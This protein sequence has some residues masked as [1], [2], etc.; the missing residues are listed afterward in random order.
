MLT[1]WIAGC[2][3]P[4]SPSSSW[5]HSGPS[6][7][8][9][10][11][12]GRPVTWPSLPRPGPPARKMGPLRAGLL[13]ATRSA[14]R[15]H[16]RRTLCPLGRDPRRQ[17]FDLALD[18]SGDHPGSRVDAKKKSLSASERVESARQA[19]RKLTAAIEPA[20]WVW[21]DEFGSTTGLTRRRTPGRRAGSG[22]TPA[23]PGNHGP[24]RTTITS[25][26]LAGLGP[27]LILDEAMTTR[28]VRVLRPARAGPDAPAGP[29]RRRWTTS[30]SIRATGSAS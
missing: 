24:N 1:P 23:R 15:R 11:A 3:G 19:W 8:G 21:V 26:T 30:A 7:V 10:S 12:A 27:G 20:R 14:P 25:L 4:R 5:F 16:P 28:G 9:S 6:N 17:G 22:P 2:P 18:E 13:A 29:D